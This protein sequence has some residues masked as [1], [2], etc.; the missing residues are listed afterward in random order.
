MP[1][2]SL[3]HSVAEQERLQRQ[4][5]YLRGITESIW[6]TAGI[7]PGLRVLDV[8]CGVGDTTFLAA[9]LVG[10]EGFVVGMDRSADA[11]GAARRRA[12]TGGRTNVLFV[13]GELGS[14]I[15]DQGPFDAVVGRYVLIHQQDIVAALCSLRDLVRPAGLVAF[16]E[17]ELD[18]RFVSDPSSDFAL[19]VFS[20]LR[21]AFRLSGTQLNVVS[22][23]PRYF[24]EAGFGWPE[25]EI[26]PLVGCGPD[27]FGPSYVVSTLNALAPLLEK[28]GVV[29]AD[30]L[31]LDTL[32][33]RLRES[34]ANGAAS[35]A[36]INGG[37]WARRP[38][39][40]G[41]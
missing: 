21:E 6:R 39:T 36:Q 35:M 17:L 34:C 15:P 31:G 27:S 26:H 4:A 8:G 20:W 5:G 2:Y 3:G 10:P 1:E 33:A 32:E 7:M 24:Y 25:T 16:H 9:D 14:P 11:I 37:V 41:V 22:Q 19:R 28:A 30:E 23:M 12:E 40:F 38:R 18:L 13:Q 29:T